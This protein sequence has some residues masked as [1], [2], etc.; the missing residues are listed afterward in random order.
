[1]KSTNYHMTIYSYDRGR[2]WVHEEFILKGKR[3]VKLVQYQEH[4]TSIV[5]SFI[6][7]TEGGETK[8]N[9]YMD[10]QG[11]KKAILGRTI[12]TQNEYVGAEMRPLRT[13][14]IIHLLCNAVITSVQSKLLNGTECYLVTNF[15]GLHT[16]N[17]GEGVYINKENGL[18]MG[19][20]EYEVD[21]GDGI[22]RKIIGQEI[23][24][25]FGTVTEEDFVEP[26]I[27]KYQI[28]K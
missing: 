22:K 16:G 17:Y 8:E 4:G 21:Y 3:K 14:N 9:I 27:S 12:D 1:M 18:V 13:E 11:E 6:Y 24:Y 28:Q 5:Q 19:S 10:S 7:Q 23:E 20:A 2:A 25:E 26:D 15:K